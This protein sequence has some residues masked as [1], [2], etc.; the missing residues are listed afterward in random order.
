MNQGVI[1]RRQFLRKGAAAGTVS[2]A[3]TAIP[4]EAAKAEK[5]KYS[6]ND[7]IRVGLIGCGMR[8]IPDG[9]AALK[10][11]GVELPIVADLYDGRIERAKEVFGP[12]TVM[13]KDYSEYPGAHRY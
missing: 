3:A 5:P 11:P 6:V 8:G 13:T 2:M 12:R 9:E 10:I 7:R 4:G 1:S